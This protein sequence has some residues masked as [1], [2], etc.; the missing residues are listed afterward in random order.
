MIG[1][2]LKGLA[3][4]KV[5]ALLTA[6]AVV[7]GV[8]MV[9]GT[10]IL[11]DTTKSSF[12]GLFAASFDKTDA[13][14]SG[15]EIVKGSTAG[16]EARVPA[17]L[18]ERLRALPQVADA[19]GT[20][21]PNETNAADVT[22]ADG[23]KAGREALPISVARA[24]PRFSPLKLASGTWADG[25]GQVVL[26]AG[27]AEKEHYK[28][29]QTVVVSTLGHPHRYR[30]TGTVTF[31]D[32]KSLG[33]ASIA[34]WDVRTAQRLFDREGQ[35]DTLSLAARKGTSQAELVRAVRPLVGHRLDV[36]S[37]DQQAK[38]NAQNVEKSL[39]MIRNF[40]LAF[41]VIALLVGAFVIY[42]TLSITVAQRTREFATLRTL[43]AS[44]KQVMRSVVTEGLVVGLLASAVGLVV[45]FGIA[46]GMLALI[47]ALGVE[48]P[49][50]ATVVAGRT[51]LVSMALGVVTTLLASLVPAWRATRVAPIAAVREG[52]STGSD[53][54]GWLVA[55]L[56]RVVGWPSR[57]AGSPGEL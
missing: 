39:S 26:D 33:F 21:S 38:D 19:G 6:F 50:A 7:I 29:G 45:G 46:K 3:A 55:P 9:S 37:S 17:A 42:S 8:A 32:T 57:R 25:A 31:G 22:G 34:A 28:L 20:I 2:A 48:L 11:T 27:T 41:G 18:L 10:F 1:V 13:V 53:R 47:G 51:I 23:K 16:G 30:L 44:R 14:V 4:R 12:T 56:V 24:P 43:G 36:K 40:L 15:K 52:A 35:F 49:D 5:R 54:L